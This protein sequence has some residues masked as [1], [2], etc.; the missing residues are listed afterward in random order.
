MC[1]VENIK[2]IKYKKYEVFFDKNTGMEVTRGINGNLDPFVM[3]HPLLA[4]IGIKGY[5][6]NNDCVFCYQGK[7]QRSDMKLEDYKRIVDELVPYTNQIALGGKGN[8]NSHS[9]FNEIINYT[10]ENN[11]VPNYTTSGYDL[12]EDQVQISRKCGAVAVSISN[13]KDYTFKAIKMLQDAGIRTNLHWVLSKKSI[14][15]IIKVLQ[16]YD[17]WNGKINI[18]KLNGI[19]LLSFKPQGR[20]KDLYEWILDNND[21]IRLLSYLRRTKMSFKIGADSCLFCK[22]GKISNFTDIEKLCTD[23]CE[24]SRQSFYID[25]SMKMKPCSYSNE[26]FIDL[27]TNTIDE[28]WNSQLFINFREKLKNDPYKCPLNL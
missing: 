9:Q 5:C 18:K 12:T 22:I 15:D 24:G 6:N 17:I 2:Y 23:T 28:G 14:D 1:S 11:I 3:E 25:C 16:G 19:I 26:G 4:D 13:E 21:I 20:G 10:I 8:P 7:E 27:Y